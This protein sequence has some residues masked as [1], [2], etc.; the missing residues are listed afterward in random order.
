MKKPT[1]R[2]ALLTIG[3]V[4]ATRANAQT[5]LALDNASLSDVIQELASGR[6]TATA[7]SSTPYASSM[8][9]RSRSP[10]SSTTPSRRS[11]SRWRACRSW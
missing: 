9:M 6:I 8:P 5:T 4:A 7:P 10:P 2:D 3:A 1:R 11:N